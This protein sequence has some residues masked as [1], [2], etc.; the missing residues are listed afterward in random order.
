MKKLLTDQRGAV[1]LFVLL[2]ST[3]LMVLG[4]G[5]VTVLIDDIKIIRLDEDHKIATYMAEAGF[6]EAIYRI[7]SAPNYF[8]DNPYKFESQ[9][10]FFEKN[11]YNVNIYKEGNYVTITSNG[12]NKNAKREINA[13][14]RVLTKYPQV[15]NYALVLNSEVFDLNLNLYPDLSIIVDGDV[16]SNGK[17]TLNEKARINR[18]ISIVEKKY[19]N[20]NGAEIKGAIF[21]DEIC[22]DL[23]NI[24]P[25][26]SGDIIVKQGTHSFDGLYSDEDIILVKNIYKHSNKFNLQKKGQKDIDE[27]GNVRIKGKIKGKHIVIAEGDILVEGNLTYSNPK[28]DLLL[29]ISLKDIKITHNTLGSGIKV[30]AYLLSNNNVGLD[31]G[32]KKL[33]IFGGVALGKRI[34][35]DNRCL[36]DINIIYDKRMKYFDLVKQVG[37][38]PNSD[39]DNNVEIIWIKYK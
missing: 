4:V 26:A 21:E 22:F 7:K 13:K 36:Q 28:E 1:L 27:W 33:Q 38:L 11:S 12:I 17:L 10:D 16:H 39:L 15:F 14:T 6:E 5:I 37:F 34:L 30:D 20:T 23:S 9:A 3:M 24:F 25:Q 18:N 29:L 31:P 32:V 2:L 19:L 8:I 35:L